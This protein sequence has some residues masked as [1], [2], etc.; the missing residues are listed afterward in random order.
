MEKLT[1]TKKILQCP[2]V[3]AKAVRIPT[4]E[5]TRAEISITTKEQMH[6]V[7]FLSKA[8]AAQTDS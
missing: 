1:V 7:T 5:Q 4:A 6:K 2:S 3:L 8:A